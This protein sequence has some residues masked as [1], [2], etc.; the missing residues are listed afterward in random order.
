TTSLTGSISYSGGTLLILAGSTGTPANTETAA[1]IDI[2]IQ[3]FPTPTVSLSGLCPPSQPTVRQ[4]LVPTAFVAAPSSSPGTLTVTAFAETSVKVDAED[5]F[6][7]TIIEF[8]ASNPITATSPI[9]GTSPGHLP[10]TSTTPF[11]SNG[12]TLLV[13]ANGSAMAA[14]SKVG[15]VE[16]AI[17]I[18][19]T[20]VGTANVYSQGD[21][22]NFYPTALV[23]NALVLRNVP[24]G[25]HSLSFSQ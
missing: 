15:V 10:V 5:T 13:F 14:S 2:A 24:S 22:G 3:G 25:S 11:Q 1:V 21:P 4:A 12:G 7:L 16:M 9:V 8:P 6:N 20:Q 17:S 19:G 23:T 18:D